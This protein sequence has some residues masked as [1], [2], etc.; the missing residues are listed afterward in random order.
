MSDLFKNSLSMSNLIITDID[1]LIYN[2]S[3]SNLI[4]RTYTYSLIHL[5]PE[6]Q[7][8]FSIWGVLY[9]AFD[10]LDKRAKRIFTM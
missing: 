2:I 3:L 7:L 1:I 6:S 8:S 9:L 4:I 10:L 5:I